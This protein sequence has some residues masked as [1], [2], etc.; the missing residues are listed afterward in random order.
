[1]PI[2]QT[3]LLWERQAMRLI[4]FLTR[5]LGVVI[6]LAGAGCAEEGKP[7][8]IKVGSPAPRFALTTLDKESITNRTLTG[9]IVILS[10]WSTSCSSCIKELPD[11][12]QIEES[13][14]ATVIGI[15]LDESGWKTIKPVVERHGLTYRMV[16]G[17]ERLFQ[18]FDGYGI[19]YTLLLDRSQRIAKIYRG[20][21]TKETLT[22]DIRAIATESSQRLAKGG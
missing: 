17:D 4:S 1:M 12:L 8:A 20:A 16:L 18:R 3:K 22:A 14:L 9:Q 6:I 15:A 10:F 21:V 19:P 5:F 11:L 2:E 13:A 7:E